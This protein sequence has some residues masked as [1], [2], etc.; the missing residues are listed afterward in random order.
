MR[1]IKK[2]LATLLVGI[3]ALGLVACGTEGPAD[4]VNEYF[5]NIKKGNY[6]EA[7]ELFEETLEEN[8]NDSNNQEFSEEVEKLLMDTLKKIDYK[9]NDEA[10]DGDTAIINVTVKGPNITNVLLVSMGEAIGKIF[11][12]AFTNPEISEEDTFTIME[13]LLAENLA[14]VEIDER[15]ADISLMKTE[16]GWIMNEDNLGA[17]VLG[18]PLEN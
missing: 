15:T 2:L 6:E 9:I 17:L 13:E 14:K 8:I 3:S 16:D 11:S 18:V 4:V 1:K 7:N 10:I 12:L 5:T